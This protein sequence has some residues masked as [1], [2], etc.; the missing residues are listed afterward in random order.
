MYI[1][2]ESAEEARDIWQHLDLGRLKDELMDGEIEHHEW[3][4]NVSFE[5]EEMNE[6]RF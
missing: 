2:A 3:V 6:V 1:S 4:E 5:D